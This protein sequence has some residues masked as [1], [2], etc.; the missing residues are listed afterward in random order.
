[1]HGGLLTGW[2]LLR[3]QTVVLLDGKPVTDYTMTNSVL[4]TTCVPQLLPHLILHLAP[5]AL[6]PFPRRMRQPSAV[7]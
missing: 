4:K 7:A 6:G 2:R 3:V 1:M 5:L